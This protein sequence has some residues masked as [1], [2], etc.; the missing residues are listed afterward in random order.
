MYIY[1][2]TYVYKGR[3]RDTYIYIC[4]YSH[5]DVPMGCLQLVGSLTLQVPFAKEPYKRY[6]ILQKGPIISKSL[7]IVAIP[8]PDSFEISSH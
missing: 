4:I 2:H 3:E 8:Y 7:L 6:Y 5:I 1:V